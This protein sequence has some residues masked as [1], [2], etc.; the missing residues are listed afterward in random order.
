[1]M[2]NVGRIGKVDIVKKICLIGDPAVGKSS[3]IRRYVYDE[4]QNGYLATIGTKVTV[5]TIRLAGERKGRSKNLALTIWDI[6]GHKT[7]RNVRASYYQGAEG[8]LVVCDLTRRKTLDNISHWLY[9]YKKSALKPEFVMLTN[10][11]DLK[12]RAEFELTEAAELAENLGGTN[13][14][15]SAKTGEGVEEAFNKLVSIMMNK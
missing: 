1:M 10:K 15:T 12:D 7:F 11:A 13:I 14:L 4:F 2:D 6:A 3:L 8:A 9:H 5:K